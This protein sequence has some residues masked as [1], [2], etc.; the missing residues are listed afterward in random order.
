MGGFVRSNWDEVNAT[1]ADVA[2]VFKLHIV[3]GLTI[4]LI[5]PF[6]RLV[7]IWS[8]FAALAYAARAY[9]LVRQRG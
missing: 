3:L 9:Q 5:A 7:H 6:S 1:I 4:F 2:P 8:G